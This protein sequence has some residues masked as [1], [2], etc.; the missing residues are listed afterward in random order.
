MTTGFPTAIFTARMA[1][2]NTLQA[3]QGN[4]CHSRS[5]YPAKLSFIV[6]GTI[7]TFHI[8]Q[9]LKQFTLLTKPAQQKIL[10]GIPHTEEEDKT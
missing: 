7:K 2:K 6:E 4:S 8:K 9:K 10:K 1:R 3:L 5:L